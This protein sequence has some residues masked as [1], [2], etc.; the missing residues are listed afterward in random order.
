LKNYST[1]CEEKKMKA[2]KFQ[3]VKKSLV[4]LM[5]AVMLVVGVL[6]Y[7]TSTVKAYATPRLVVT[8]ADIKGGSVKAG[9]KFSMVI[10]LKNESNYKLV[11]VSL[12]LSSDDNQIVTASGSDSLYIEKNR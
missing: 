8:G 9:D 6:S 12:K 2:T 4:L 3:N 10:H 11:N 7:Q 5:T 1:E